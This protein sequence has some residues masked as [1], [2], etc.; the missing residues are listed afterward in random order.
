MRNTKS[1]QMRPNLWQLDEGMMVCSF[2]R[3]EHR[4][5]VR[6]RATR[7][8][9]RPSDVGVVLRCAHCKSFGRRIQQ[10]IA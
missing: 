1:L 7:A 9:A 3:E 4:N 8:Q 5:G 6:P 2:W 10:Q